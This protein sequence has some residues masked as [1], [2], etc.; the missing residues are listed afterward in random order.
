VQDRA[1]ALRTMLCI[2]GGRQATDIEAFVAQGREHQAAGGVVDR[3]FK[4]L[5]AIG[6]THPLLALRAAEIDAWASGEDYARIMRGEYARRGEPSRAEPVAEAAA[7]YARGTQTIATE[8]A[9]SA[10]QAAGAARDFVQSVGAKL[11]KD[12]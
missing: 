10:K 12:P 11:R 9:S 2:A 3:I 1:I 6:R 5:N 7:H 8:L 4:I